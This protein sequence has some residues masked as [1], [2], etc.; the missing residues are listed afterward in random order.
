M[1]LTKSG[2]Y[3]TVFRCSLWFACALCGGGLSGFG[4]PAL[5]LPGCIGVN[6]LALAFEQ[7]L[8]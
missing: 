3:N 1:V 7:G 8:A 6:T 4:I 5:G 2:L